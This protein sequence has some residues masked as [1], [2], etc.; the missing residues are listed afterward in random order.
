MVVIFEVSECTNVGVHHVHKLDEHIL[1]YWFGGNGVL[2][3]NQLDMAN[4]II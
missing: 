3:I 1:E 4:C 2:E